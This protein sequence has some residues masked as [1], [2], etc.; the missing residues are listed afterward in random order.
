MSEANKFMEAYVVGERIATLSP[1]QF[2]TLIDGV[3]AG[4]EASDLPFHGGVYAANVSL[5]EDGNVGLGEALADEDNKYTAFQIE[6]I[7][8]EVTLLYCEVEQVI[9][10]STQTGVDI[11]IGGWE[12]DEEDYG[13]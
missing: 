8:P 5:D 4:L 10:L 11:G 3:C 13:G 1:E 12:S 6:Y 7:A 9:A 2:I